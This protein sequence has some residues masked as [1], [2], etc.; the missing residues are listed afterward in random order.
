[1]IDQDGFRP[2]VGIVLCNEDNHVFWARR[3]AQ[4]GWQFPQGGVQRHETVDQ[5]LYRE[6]HEEVGLS[7]EHVVMLGRTSDWLRYEVPPWMRRPQNP[8]RGQKQIWYLLRFLGKDDCVRLDTCE[9]ALGRLLVAARSDC[10][11]QA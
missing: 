9:R 10:R 6:L 7:A 4:D 2:N 1:M 8:F 11:L 3:S 5:A